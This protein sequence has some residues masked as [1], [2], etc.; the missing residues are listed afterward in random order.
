MTAPMPK[1]TRAALTAPAI[2]VGSASDQRSAKSRAAASSSRAGSM[3]RAS[4]LLVLVF[5]DR[6]L[7]IHGQD[8]TQQ[9]REPRFAFSTIPL[10][11]FRRQLGFARLSTPLGAAPLEGFRGRFRPRGFRIDRFR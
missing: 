4:T 5:R 11:P 2:A 6:L 10:A 7:Y 8:R 9:G 1:N 3:G